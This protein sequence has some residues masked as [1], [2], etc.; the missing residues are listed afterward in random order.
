MSSRSSAVATLFPGAFAFVMATGIIAIG[1]GGGGHGGRV[2]QAARE[3]QHVVAGGRG[4]QRGAV[5]RRQREHGA[6]GQVEQRRRAQR[7]PVAVPR[8]GL[9]RP[10]RAGAHRWASRRTGTCGNGTSGSAAWNWPGVLS[11]WSAAQGSE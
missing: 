11:C 2:A 6:R 7:R 8:P 4:A 3:H 1:A 9:H 5:G 10:V